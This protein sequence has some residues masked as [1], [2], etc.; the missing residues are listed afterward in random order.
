MAITASFGMSD[1]QLFA[2]IIRE[3][4][5]RKMPTKSIL[6]QKKKDGD[7]LTADD[8]PDTKVERRGQHIIVPEEMPLNVARDWLYRLMENEENSVGFHETFQAYPLDGAHA[9][10]MALAEIYG[11]TQM[12]PTPGFWGNTPPTM[13]N[14]QSDVHET[15]KVPWGRIVIPEIEGH[16]NT[17]F[18][19]IHGRPVFAVHGEVRN[20][21]RS[22]VDKIIELTRKLVVSHSIY[23]GKPL[24]MHFPDYSSADFDPSTDMPRFFDVG[25]LSPSDLILSK[26]IQDQINISIYT[27]IRHWEYLKKRGKKL[28]RGILLHGKWGVGK[29]LTAKVTA[30]MCRQYGW[31]FI[32]L[33]KVEQLARAIEFARQ[34]QRAFIFAED[35][36]RI[37]AKRDDILN[38]LLNTIDGVVGHNDHIMVALTTNHIGKIDPSVLRHGRIDAV[39]P[40]EPPDA[41]A[42]IRLVKLYAKDSL[43]EGAD[44]TAVGKALEGKLPAVIEAV[45]EHSTLAAIDRLSPTW[46]EGFTPDVIPLEPEDLL[47][48]AAGEEKHLELLVQEEEDTRSDL[49]R[50]ASILGDRIADAMNPLNGEQAERQARQKEAK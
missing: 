18:G 46:A 13:I 4:D 21:H 2:A 50:A 1:D 44:L 11:F 22:K 7:E 9:F 47:R 43:V 42:A 34:Y 48:S 23:K 27:P 26:E 16:M 15:V 28:K 19:K 31:T 33:E 41:E 10:A 5:K 14:V 37:A 49:E 29:T 25:N 8:F 6:S 17:T 36:D 40:M 3:M 38:F 35:F 12:T 39:I 24:Q 32:Y 20:K 30:V 45:V